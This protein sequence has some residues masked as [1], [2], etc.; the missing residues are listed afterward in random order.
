MGFLDKFLRHPVT[1]V[2]TEPIPIEFWEDI[3]MAKAHE[4]MSWESPPPAAKEQLERLG[5]DALAKYLKPLASDT[6]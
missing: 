1:P 4:I 5:C 2:S 6:P 3:D